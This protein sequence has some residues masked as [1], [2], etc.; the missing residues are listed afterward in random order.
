MSR[1]TYLTGIEFGA[2]VIATLRDAVAECLAVAK[3][4]GVK[5]PRCWRW[6]SDGAGLPAAPDACGRCTEVVL[7][8]GVELDPA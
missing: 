4:E 6:R 1:I 8:L 7:A 5:C 3:A 2:G